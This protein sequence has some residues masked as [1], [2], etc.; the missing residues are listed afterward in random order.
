MELIDGVKLLIEVGIDGVIVAII[1]ELAVVSESFL[2][3]GD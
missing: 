3:G 2:I 1:A